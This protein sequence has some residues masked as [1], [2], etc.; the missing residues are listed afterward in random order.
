M[1][2][3]ILPLFFGAAAWAETT[4][5]YIIVGGGTTGL[6]VA[7][8]LTEDPKSKF[9]SYADCLTCY[10]SCSGLLLFGVMCTLW[11]ITHFR[12]VI[13]LRETAIN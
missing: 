8:R 11:C 9:I 13:Q 7:N 4:Y 12:S 1:H 6:V 10:Y 5:D 2:S 3:L